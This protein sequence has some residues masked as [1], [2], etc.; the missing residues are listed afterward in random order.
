M[1]TLADVQSMSGAIEAR[2]AD[3][4]HIN[5][6]LTRQLVSFQANK[7]QPRYRWFRYKEGF[8]EALVHYLLD[9]VGLHSGTLLDPFAGVGTT[10][11]V[12]NDRGL[13]AVGIELLPIGWEIMQVRDLVQHADSRALAH[14]L[15]HW[16][17]VQSWHD[18]PA[19]PFPHLRITNGAFAAETE[20]ALGQYL[21]AAAQQPAPLDRVLRFAALC[22][23]EDISYTR[24]DG[25]YLR[26]D[27]RSG[28]RV[29][30]KPFDKGTILPFADAIRAK[31]TEIAHDLT[32]AM[33]DL[34]PAPSGRLDIHLG[35]CLALLPALPTASMDGLITSPPYANRYDYTRTYALELALLGVDEH[36]LRDLRQD[37]LSCTVEN[38]DKPQLQDFFSRAT[39]E[40]ATRA[41]EQQAEL[42]AILGYLE[43][44]KE[45]K[46]LNNNGIP[47]MLRNYFYELA[48][49]IFEAA[50]V[51]KPNAPFV[52]VNDNV[53]YSGAIIPVDL[54]LSDI[55]AA[56]GLETEVI[57]VLPTNKGNSSQQMGAHGRE[58]LRK[59]VYVW[60]KA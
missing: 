41:W 57:W 8:S 55:A 29:G 26:W 2:Y 30:A 27:D 10:L 50:R 5:P 35:S 42:Q 18:H 14:D 60:R 49:V 20:H 25:Q 37:L 44:Q 47:R 46:A 48:L 33:L 39:F 43:W 3:R 31:L 56:A 52:M 28:R 17:K 58:A 38:R 24:K 21:S 9:Q 13:N 6:Q 40:A 15:L 1:T 19:A 4:L 12:A 54:I 53:R 45:Q 22:V 11:F 59:C 36:G 7:N 51:L 32:P 34:F 16:A 23:L